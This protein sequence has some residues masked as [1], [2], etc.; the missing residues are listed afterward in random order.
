MGPALR[1]ANSWAEETLGGF[2]V[3]A[4]AS[5]SRGARGSWDALQKC[6]DLESESWTSKRNMMLAAPERG[7]GVREGSFLQL[8]L[9]PGEGRAQG[10]WRWLAQQLDTVPSASKGHLNIDL[11]TDT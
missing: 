7:R 10:C 6:P 8:S 1:M 3:T 2:A 4:K 5:A 11:P 9:I